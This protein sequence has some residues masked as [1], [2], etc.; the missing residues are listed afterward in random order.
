MN[1]SI[2]QECH[3]RGR[4]VIHHKDENHDNDVAANRQTLCYRCHL[5]AHRR[6]DR[7][8]GVRNERLPVNIS[9]PSVGM[10]YIRDQYKL[11]FP[12]A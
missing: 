3:K 4:V 2:C 5:V 8:T 9:P 10:D 11:C 6:A 12:R 7:G 1:Q